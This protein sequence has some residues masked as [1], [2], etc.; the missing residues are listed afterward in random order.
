MRYRTW[1]IGAIV[2]AVCLAAWGLHAPS[3]DETLRKR[4]AVLERMEGVSWQRQSMPPSDGRFLRIMVES[5][6][7]KRV[8]EIGTS[9]GYA[10]L[11]LGSGLEQ[12]GGRLW[13]IEIDASR[14]RE[15]RRNLQ[16]AGLLDS[17]V[18]AIEGDAF[19][20]IPKLTGPFDIVY[21]DA[22]KEDYDEFFALF[23]PMVR[24]GGVIL[25]HNAI[26]QAGDMKDFLDIVTKHPELDTV[27]LRTLEDPKTP[28]PD[29]FVVCYKRKV[30]SKK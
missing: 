11:W 21:L 15:A 5:T 17:V 19:K 23:Y 26:L 22:W 14:A 9:H 24:E 3:R 10:A 2:G 30:E 7:A 18:T 4:A 12:T 8:L 29:G 28:A 1:R 13:T 16:E 6:G 25:A 27:F 20:E